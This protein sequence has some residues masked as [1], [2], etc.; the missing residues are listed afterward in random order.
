MKVCVSVHGRF[1]AFE[2]ARGLHRRGALECL[3]TTYPTFVP[4]RIIG[5]DVSLRTAPWLE[6]WR[7]LYPKLRLGPQPDLAISKAFG[8]FAAGALK[9]IQADILVGW[10]SATLE[11]IPVARD[12]GMKVVIERGSTHIAHQTEVLKDEYQRY[13][14]DF[15]ATAPGMV[16]RELREYEMADAIAVPSRFAARTFVERGIPEHKLIVAPM[17]VD[18]GQFTPEPTNTEDRLPRIIFV[19]TVGLRKGVPLLLRA[20]ARLKDRTEL[21]LVGPVEDDFRPILA[22]LPLD[23]VVVRGAVAGESLQGLYADADIFCLPSVEEGFGMVVTEAMAC[24]LPPVVTERV[25][26][27]DTIVPGEN[28]LI[29]AH[30]DETALAEALASLVSDPELRRAMGAAARNRV[31]T[32]CSWDDYVDRVV[33]AYE[34]L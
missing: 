9:S 16:D 13:D 22:A 15:Q 21:H 25:G 23:N 19:G 11:A 10:S 32:G 18:L 6:V 8:Q 12:K 33:A 31:M 27:S 20:F 5:P 3:L 28:G 29:V 4:K 30:G 24:G 1:H 14:L 2:L 34:K 17:G 7:R 26:A